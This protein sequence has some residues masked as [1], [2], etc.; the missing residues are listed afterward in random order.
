MS[1]NFVVLNKFYNLF[2]GFG[3][4]WVGIFVVGDLVVFIIF[5]VIGR[6]SYGFIGLN[7]DVI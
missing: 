2:F 6:Y 1:V 4:R 3:Y 7:W 5:V